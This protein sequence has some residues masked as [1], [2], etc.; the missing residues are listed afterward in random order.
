MLNNIQDFCRV[1]VPDYT[2]TLQKNRMLPTL[3]FHGV[4]CGS[5]KT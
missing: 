1:H 3:G 2:G 5:K 4:T